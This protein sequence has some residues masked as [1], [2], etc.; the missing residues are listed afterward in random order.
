MI[1]SKNISLVVIFV[2]FLSSC[3]W[4][5]KEKQLNM[6]SQGAKIAQK[7]IVE[8]AVFLDELVQYLALKPGNTIDAE[9]FKNYSGRVKK[10]YPVLYEFTKRAHEHGVLYSIN[11]KDG[12]ISITVARYV[13]DYRVLNFNISPNSPDFPS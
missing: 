5:Q 7:F 10:K 13:T 3:D 6:I 8:D 1:F 4:G 2:A 9:E 11:V 12:P